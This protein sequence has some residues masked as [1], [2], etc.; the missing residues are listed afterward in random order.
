MARVEVVSGTW[1][2]GRIA[3]LSVRLY[4]LPARD[5]SRQEAI[6]WMKDGHSFIPVVDGEAGPALVLAEVAG[7]EG[8]DWF[9][10]STTDAV[11]ADSLPFAPR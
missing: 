2:D 3:T 10:R 5:L 7:D 8:D 4:G 1:N 6:S 11:P 9:I